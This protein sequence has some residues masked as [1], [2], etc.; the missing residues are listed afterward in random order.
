MESHELDADRRPAL[1]P[2]GVLQS[3]LRKTT[4]TL[5]REVAFPSGD[6]PRW[7]DFEWRIAEA[8]AVMQ[9]ISA[10]LSNRSRWRGP[11]RWEAFLAGQTEHTLLRRQ[12]IAKLL[13]HMH[14]EATLAHLPAVAL[15]GAE[16]YGMGAYPRGDRPMSDVDLLVAPADVEVA[17]GVLASLGYRQAFASARHL[18]FESLGPKNAGGFGEHIENPIK[19]ELHTRI[20]EQLP[21]RETDITALVFPR[22]AAPGLN[23]YPSTAALMRHLL[24]HAAGNMRARSLRFIQLHDIAVLA[25]QMH[26]EHWKE[27]LQTQAGGQSV[28]WAFA[29]LELTARYFPKAIARDLLDS[30]A[31]ACPRL[32]RKAT[33][34]HTSRGCFVGKAPYPGLS[35]HRMVALASRSAGVHGQS[36][37]ARPRKALDPATC[38]KPVALRS[39]GPVVRP[40][41][42]PPHLRWIFS[43]PPRVQ[44]IYPIRVALGIQPP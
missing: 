33:C 37:R 13:E 19:I 10:L 1:P 12:K 36:H 14:I 34:R 39:I 38:R 15:K 27:L 31:S 21:A 41:A 29:P 25:T 26:V 42:W 7:N 9:G 16:L 24:L 8:A 4:E 2:L 20:A 28:W 5:I 18:T 3:A 43:N 11:Q 44:A 32:L 6:A 40:V 35:R 22:D 30:T 17:A 23:P